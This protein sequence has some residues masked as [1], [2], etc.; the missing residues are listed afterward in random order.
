MG[1][2][3]FRETK[4]LSLLIKRSNGMTLI[5]VLAVLAIVAMIMILAYS[6]LR[7][8]FQLAKARDSRRKTDLKRISIA[9]EDYAGD[10][11]CYPSLIYQENECLPSGEIG[12]YL[13]K[14]PCDPLTGEQYPYSSPDGCSQFALYAALELENTISYGWG[15]Y[16]LT[17]PNLQVIPTILITPTSPI[18]PPTS[19]PTQP[20]SPTNTPAPPPPGSNWWGCKSG[21]CVRISG[22]AECPTINFQISDCGASSGGGCSNPSNDCH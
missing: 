20:L 8:M 21:V 10:N 4:L 12:P 14:I 17:S 18:V 16:V 6:S 9:L 3:N 22:P 19:G 13:S 2:G 11:P 5:E 1:R 7:P 15:N